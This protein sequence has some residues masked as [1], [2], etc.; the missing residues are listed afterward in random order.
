MIATDT[1]SARMQSASQRYRLTYLL[2]L[3][4]S[5]GLCTLSI[6]F[7]VTVMTNTA[8]SGKSSEGT[9]GCGVDGLER[10]EIMPLPG[11]QVR[12]FREYD[13][14]SGWHPSARMDYEL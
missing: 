11:K 12:A 2:R 13:Q 3:K 5:D 1:G 6:M 10:M 8:S 14:K 7:R 4:K 9:A